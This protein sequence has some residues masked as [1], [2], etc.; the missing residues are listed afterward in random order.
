[1]AENVTGNKVTR[2]E[3]WL[4]RDIWALPSLSCSSVVHWEA[5]CAAVK[6][7]LANTHTHMY[8]H[9]WQQHSV[10]SM[11]RGDRDRVDSLHGTLDMI[12]S[13]SQKCLCHYGGTAS[14]PREKIVSAFFTATHCITKKQNLCSWHLKPM[15]KSNLF[16]LRAEHYRQFSVSPFSVTKITQIILSRTASD[17][18]S[19]SLDES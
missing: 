4:W 17:Y 11:M 3:T 5:K 7:C 19:H 6:P 16:R 2:L 8:T 18:L 15:A 12:R 9:I 13:H 10:S 14:Q 1:M